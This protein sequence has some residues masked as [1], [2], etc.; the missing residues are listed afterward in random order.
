MKSFRSVATRNTSSSNMKQENRNLKQIFPLSLWMSHVQYEK[1]SY[2]LWLAQRYN[3]ANHKI[4]VLWVKLP[5]LIGQSTDRIDHGPPL[6]EK[7]LLNQLSWLLLH[8]QFI[9]VQLTCRFIQ[10][11]VFVSVSCLALMGIKRKVR[12]KAD[13]IFVYTV[14]VT[15]DM[16]VSLKN[17]FYC[18]SRRKFFTNKFCRFKRLYSQFSTS[19]I[20]TKNYIG[21]QQPQ[22]IIS[23][24][25]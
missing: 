6:Q 23:D 11:Y 17:D 25:G 10:T 22:K 9:L 8:L 18:S 7:H 4:V 24:L 20:V 3:N 15:I 1:P 12:V 16:T 14:E 5:V 21:N 13:E 2:L 19:A